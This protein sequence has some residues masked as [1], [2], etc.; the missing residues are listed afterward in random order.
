MNK[1]KKDPR[2]ERRTRANSLVKNMRKERAQ[3]LSL[4][5]QLSRPSP[6]RGSRTD[7]DVLREFCQV[8]VDYIAAGHFGLYERVASGKERRHNIAQ[9][10]AGLLP[11]LQQTTEVAVA[12]NEKYAPDAGEPDLDRLIEDLSELGE[13]LTTRLELEDRLFSQVLGP[14]D[15][16]G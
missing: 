2:G 5:M 12:F 11:R 16:P 10:A 9:L 6:G 13:E 4:L 3:L 14:A 7:P 8:L 15:A 1:N